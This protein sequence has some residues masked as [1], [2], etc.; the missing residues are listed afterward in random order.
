MKLQSFRR[1]FT[2]DYKKDYQDLIESLSVSLN[3]GIESLY[4][5]LNNNVT[6]RDNM[7]A[8]I[9]DVTVSVDASG[10]PVNATS[11]ALDF[12][13]QIDGV[14]VLSAFNQTNA[15]IYPTTAPFISYTQ[16]TDSIIINNI[17]GLQPG[18]TYLIRVVAFNKA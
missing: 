14:M 12:S 13:G 16:S 15:N 9:K 10:K 3:N 18:N 5:A 2:K 4:T 7:K 8:S 1:L 6:L 17:T 11:F